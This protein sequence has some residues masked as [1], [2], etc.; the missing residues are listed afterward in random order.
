MDIFAHALW[1]AAATVTLRPK[2]KQPIR[3][4][5]CVAWS[6]LP[7]LAS[8]VIPAVVRIG[9]WLTGSSR[10]LLP[11]GTGPRFDWVWQIYNGTHSAV[12]FALV[13]GAI[14]LYL[15]RLPLEM[16][17]WAL[18]IVIDIFTHRGLFAVKSLWP[19]SGYR[20]DGLPWETRWLLAANWVALAAVWLLLFVRMR[21]GRSV[22][23]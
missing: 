20:V 5:W 15:R 2:L 10:T 17:G 12:V 1:T 11:D 3:V 6:V 16:L 21:P 23:R 18:H 13:F 8:F 7:D 9:R 4:G 19:L 22:S 14:W